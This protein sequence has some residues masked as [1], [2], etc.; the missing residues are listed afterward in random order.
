MKGARPQASFDGVCVFV[1]ADGKLG[2]VLVV[3]RCVCV[4]EAKC[5][6]KGVVCT[7]V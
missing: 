2:C 7:C 1:G 5:V 3:G 4:W 6:G